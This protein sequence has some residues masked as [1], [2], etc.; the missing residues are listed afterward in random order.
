[1]KYGYWSTHSEKALKTYGK[2]AKPLLHAMEQ[3]PLKGNTK[4]ISSEMESRFVEILPKLPLHPGSPRHLFNDLMPVL[5]VISAFYL[6]LREHGYNTA[7]IGRIEYDAFLQ[8]FDSLPKPVR[9]IARN[10]MVSP[11]FCAAM[12]ST[13][14]KMTEN[15]RD[16]TFFLE[17]SFQKKP[18][19]AT[20]MTCSQCAMISFMEKNGLEEMKYICNVFDFA[21][22]ESFGLGL[23]QPARLGAGDSSCRYVFTKNKNDTIIP[24]NIR[25][26]L[27]TTI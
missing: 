2:V 7:Q 12:K 4:D 21:Q 3:Y 26:I 24:D 20:C 23:K 17:Y 18:N 22:A 25:D 13:T 8:Y 5:G 10:F 14:R 9:Y 15:G 6:V 27:N 16:D 11:L 19:R 1:M